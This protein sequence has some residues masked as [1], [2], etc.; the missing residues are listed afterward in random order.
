MVTH[1]SRETR[2][3]IID[4][5]AR[6]I[7]NGRP[8]PEQA[9]QIY[10]LVALTRLQIRRLDHFTAHAIATGSPVDQVD[11]WR[12]VL[13][14]KLRKRRALVIAGTE[15]ITAANRGQQQLW[16]QLMREGVL[17]DQARKEWITTPG[18]RRCARCAAMHGQT[19]LVR[20]LFTSQRFGDV[21]QP[22]LHPQCRCAMGIARRT[23][24]AVSQ[25]V[26]PFVDAFPPRF[27]TSDRAAWA[28]KQA[29]RD[30]ARRAA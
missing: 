9:R 24:L 1:F 19:V 23:A 15:T 27:S 21:K 11:R 8:V 13:A 30:R 12:A 25:Q 22:A 2:L 17:P 6:A 28:L 5:V 3:G 4:V 14:E 16:E 7:H 10:D 29:A 20:A 26:R 18:D